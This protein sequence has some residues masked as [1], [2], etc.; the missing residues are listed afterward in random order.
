MDDLYPP[1]SMVAAG[2]RR[3]RPEP[4]VCGKKGGGR[5]GG[6]YS[7]MEDP[8]FPSA[9][10]VHTLPAGSY[11]PDRAIDVHELMKQ[12]MFFS[13]T[14]SCDDHFQKNVP[15]PSTIYGVSDQYLVL[16]SFEKLQES[17]VEVGEFQFNFMVQGVTQDRNIGVRETLATVIGIQCCD[18]SIPNLP[19][20]NFEVSRLEAL[21][22]SLKV[23]Q[24]SAAWPPGPAPPPQ[25]NP[26]ASVGDWRTQIPF[27]DRITMYFK[28]IGLQSYS[29]INSRRHHFEFEATPY[30]RI[31]TD[32]ETPDYDRLML[33][34]ISQFSYFLFTEPI[35]A[36]HGMTVAFFNPG[37]PVS[38][39]PDV[40]YGV[41]VFADGAAGVLTFRY[42]DY[43]NLI[44]LKALDRIFIKGLSTSGPSAA[45]LDRWV[46]R[47]EGQLVSGEINGCVTSGPTSSTSGTTVTFQLNPKVLVPGGGWGPGL[48]PIPSRQQV[49]VYIAKNRLRIPLRL[50]TVVPKLTNYV[51]P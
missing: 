10:Q 34:P 48:T 4:P 23:L 21:D 5:G 17:S 26:V 36:I 7:D 20:D 46:T 22:P 29:D 39:P 12:G 32:A 13:S 28:E 41:E 24:L 1:C 40:L 2:E 25:E 31:L 6:G 35:Q 3:G 27:S 50:R 33:R 37:E 9:R 15:C 47:P 49:E 8:L 14:P 11:R 18:F 38:F 51:S 30:P 42:V 45:L 19:L 16:D 43:T 44:N